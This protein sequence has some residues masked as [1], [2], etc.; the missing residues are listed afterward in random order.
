MIR[1]DISWLKGS[2]LFQF[3]GSY[4]HNWNYHQRTDNGGGINYQTV[5]AMGAGAGSGSV[6]GMNMTGYIP[7]GLGSTWSRDYAIV[8]GIPSLTQIAFTRTGSNLELTPPSTPAFDQST[9]PFY[10][11]YFSDT[12]K[13]KPTFTVN[14]GLGWTLEMPPVEKDGKQVVLVGADNKPIDT[15]QYL[16]AR[17][18]A[19]LNGQVYNPE[20]GFT[21]VGN[22]AG[23]PKY[24]YNHN[25]PIDT[26]QYLNAREQAALN[27]QVYNPE[28]G[29]TLVGNVAGH[30][31][32][33]YNHNKPIDTM[34]YLN[35]RE[36]AALNGQVYNPEVG[37]TLVGNVAGHPKYPYNPFYKSFSPRI[38]P[39][40][41]PRFDSGLLGDVFGRNKTVIRAGYS[42]LYGRLNGVGL[43]LVPLLGTGL[44]QAVQCFGPLVDGTCSGGTGTPTNALRLGPAAN[45]WDGLVAPLPVP[46]QTLSQPDFPGINE[47]AAGAGEGLDPNFRPSMSHQF[48][49][50]VQRQINNKFSVE[51]G[52][53]GRKISH[54]FQP[55]NLNAVPYM[56]TIGGQSFA[57]AYGQMVWQYCGGNAGLAGGFCGGVNGNVMNP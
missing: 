25:K 16:N 14:Y 37:F 54:E 8:L 7:A 5:Y 20:V 12:W 32:Y 15:M 46:G 49:F 38:A 2:H 26:M 28:V 30:P 9:I 35:A 50:T 21:L 36:Q 10:N 57:K 34:Q 4:Q 56:M 3:G 1:D 45:G 29:F 42:I 51:F 23:H 52:Y 18:Q 24:P 22:V 44:I 47:I 19:A 11:L 55:I 53:I 17:E 40:W 13:M 27:G 31:K 48:D 6:N 43:V 39:A 41:N 33:P